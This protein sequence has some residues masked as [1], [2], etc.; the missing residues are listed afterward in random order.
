MKKKLTA[1]LAAVAAV[2]IVISCI[3]GVQN[4]QLRKSAEDLRVRLETAES[5]STA[6]AQQLSET[7]TSAESTR[8]DL[9]RQLGETEAARAELETAKADL[10]K[11][12]SDSAEASE[13]LK[14]QLEQR[15]AELESALKEKEKQLTRAERALEA[16]RCNACLIFANGD[17]SVTNWG[18]A[19][20]ADG[21]VLVTPASVI[22]EGDY[23]V[24]L[25]FAE[26]VSGL[27]L[28][29]IS[30]ENGET[31]FPG[32]FIRLNAVRVNGQAVPFTAGYTTS[33]DEETTRL[34]L[35]RE[36]NGEA[37]VKR[38]FD[39]NTAEAASVLVDRALFEGVT[40]LEAD[41]SLLTAPIDYGTILYSSSDGS[42]KSFGPGNEAGAHAE[43]TE[44]RGP[45]S[46]YRVSM[47]FDEPAHDL[48]LLALAVHRG[49]V[50]FPGYGLAVTRLWVNGERKEALDGLKG[51]TSSDDGMETRMNL[52]NQGVGELPEDARS[53][54]GSL[55]DA[56][57]VWVNPAD[58][59]GAER[60]EIEF[61]YRPLPEREDVPEAAAEPERE[62][63]PE[64]EAVPETA[65]EPETAVEPEAAAEP[66][67]PE[68]QETAA[69]AD[70]AETDAEGEVSQ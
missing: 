38:C 35:Y 17:W 65:A 11:Q 15:I 32:A 34:Y 19:D 5:Q 10:E 4:S 21:S 55:E 16:S 46:G 26:P 28:A 69:E 47:S 64:T 12:M 48:S 1:A 14:T 7:E 9:N 18:T 3:F 2:A 59:E 23:T 67:T 24:G 58:F 37:E 70:S 43:T 30:I 25:T 29:G 61:S 45:G 33:E 6:L 44:I 53:L 66:E 54:T 20:S 8:T 41:F 63:E 50:T 60:I 62:A 39:G 68:E 42:V 40:S 36:W 13:S 57:A 49:E 52:Y 56:S 22:G 51:Y 31:D 27:S